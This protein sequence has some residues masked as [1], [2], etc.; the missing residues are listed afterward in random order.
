MAWD[1]YGDRLLPGHC[2][3]HPYVHEEYPCPLCLAENKRKKEQEREL[4]I[5]YAEEY[6]KYCDELCREHFQGQFGEGI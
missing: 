5:Y 6:N 2:E 3:V 4:E 1:I